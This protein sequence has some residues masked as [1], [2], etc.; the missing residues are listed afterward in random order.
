VYGG[1]GGAIA[2]G[3]MG[4]FLGGITGNA[5]TRLTGRTVKIAVGLIIIIFAIIMAQN[6]LSGDP[7][8]GQTDDSS[9]TQNAGSYKGRNPE[10]R[11]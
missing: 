6:L 3:V 4:L 10:R 2:G 8:R 9:Q 7:R 11:D 5:L 1:I